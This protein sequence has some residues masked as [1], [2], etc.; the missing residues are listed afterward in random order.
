MLYDIYKLLQLSTWRLQVEIEPL[1]IKEESYNLSKVELAA[2]RIS[3]TPLLTYKI[4][5]SFISIRGQDWDC[6]MK[7]DKKRTFFHKVACARKRKELHC[8][9]SSWWSAP[10]IHFCMHVL[11]FCLVKCYVPNLWWWFRTWRS[12]II[13]NHAHIISN[14][15]PTKKGTRTSLPTWYQWQAE[16]LIMFERCLSVHKHSIALVSFHMDIG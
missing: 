15:L 1:D 4:R 10:S 13:R 2:R 14:L 16:T 5:D 6:C 7:G 8:N 12:K 3:K 9:A 11:L